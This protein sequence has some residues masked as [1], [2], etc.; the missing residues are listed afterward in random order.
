MKKTLLILSAAL[1]YSTISFAQDDGPK[2]K[3]IKVDYKY[4]YGYDNNGGILTIPAKYDDAQYFEDGLASVKIGDKWGFIDEH[5]DTKIPFK[6]TM[7]D[8]LLMA[9]PPS[10]KQEAKITYTALSTRPAYW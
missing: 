2:L 6:L 10:G 3:P 8:Y 7:P 4:G 9:M 5:G 1:L